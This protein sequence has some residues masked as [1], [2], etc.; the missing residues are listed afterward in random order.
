V[1]VIPSTKLAEGGL[2]V[3]VP[4]GTGLTVIVGVGSE[5]TVSLIA[6]IVAVP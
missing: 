1:G 2:T 3:T 5:L 6:V 4:T